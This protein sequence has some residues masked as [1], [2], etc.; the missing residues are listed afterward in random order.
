MKKKLNPNSWAF[1]LR[2]RFADWL[3]RLSVKVRPLEANQILMAMRDL[4]IYGQGVVRV[5]PE[6]LMKLQES[7]RASKESIYFIFPNDL[8]YESIPEEFRGK[9]LSLSKIEELLGKPDND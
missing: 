7:K 3:V 4:L 6:R 8:P 5:D 9:S 2:V 1:K